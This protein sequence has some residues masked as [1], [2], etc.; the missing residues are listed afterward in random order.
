MPKS[1]TRKEQEPGSAPRRGHDL[2]NSQI[3]PVQAIVKPPMIYNI[4]YQNTGQEPLKPIVDESRRLEQNRLRSP[5]FD[6]ER[7]RRNIEA[8][9]LKMHEL[10]QQGEPPR[11]FKVES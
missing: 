2:V 1:L 7:F 8:A 4:V 3:D 11:S 6:A 9:Y 5:L 10:A